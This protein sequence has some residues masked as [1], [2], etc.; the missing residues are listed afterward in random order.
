MLCAGLTLLNL[1]L[2]TLQPAK[3]EAMTRRPGL[4]RVLDSLHHAL[5]LGFAPVKVWQCD[6]CTV[7]MQAGC[8]WTLV[9]FPDAGGSWLMLQYQDQELQGSG[10]RHLKGAP[11]GSPPVACSYNLHRQH[12]GARLPDMEP[13]LNESAC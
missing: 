5:D 11:S 3:F 12:Q 9:K 8:G 1:S 13:A 10:W 6:S 4:Q 7:C 2:D